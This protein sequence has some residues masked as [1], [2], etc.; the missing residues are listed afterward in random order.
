MERTGSAPLDGP[1]G[2]AFDV[3]VFRTYL[4][5]LLPPGKSCQ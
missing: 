5:T 4:L 2:I 3:G 1:T